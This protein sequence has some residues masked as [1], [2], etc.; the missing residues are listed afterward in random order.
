MAA[1]SS[2][3]PKIIRTEHRNMKKDDSLEQ[4]IR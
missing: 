4:T 3:E 2:E 1:A